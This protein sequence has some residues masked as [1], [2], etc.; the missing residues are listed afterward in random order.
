MFKKNADCKPLA[1]TNGRTLGRLS[2]ASLVGA[3]LFVASAPGCGNNLTPPPPEIGQEGIELVQGG[4]GQFL[5]PVTIGNQ[6]FNLLLDTGARDVLVFDDLIAADNTAVKRTDESVTLI[7]GSGPRIGKVAIAPIRVG[8]HSADDMRIMLV[9][10]PTSRGDPS[11]VP[12]M[13]D[14]IFGLRFN[15]GEVDD[16]G[17]D[18]DV[19]LLVLQPRVKEFQL[20]LPFDGSRASLVFGS[21]PVLEVSDPAFVFGVKTV[22]EIGEDRVNEN[23]ADLEVPFRVETRL[24]TANSSDL[25]I[26]LDTG[27][28][29]K[30]VLDREVAAQ[31]GFD[32]ETG[33]WNLDDDE[34]VNFFFVGNSGALPIEPAF[35][36]DEI[37]VTNLSG[38]TFDAVL[39]LDR[40]QQYIIGFTFVD[41]SLGGPDGTFRFL[42]RRDR[43]EAFRECPALSSNFVP[44]PGLNSTADDTSPNISADGSTIAFASDRSGGRGGIDFYLYRIGEGLIDTSALNSSANDVDPSVNEDGTLVVFVSDRNGGSDLF[45]YDLEAEAFIELPGLNTDDAPERSPYLSADGRYIAF[46]SERGDEPGETPSDIFLYDRDTQSLVD[47]PGLNSEADEF[48]PAISRNAGLITFDSPNR[49]D[50]Q[51]NEDV[52]IYDRNSAGLIQLPDIVNTGSFDGFVGVSADGRFLA[53]TSDGDTRASGSI[54]RDIKLF[55]RQGQ[56]PAGVVGSFADILGLNSE[57]EE[58]EVGLNEDGSLVVFHSRRCG[59]EGGLDI[60]LYR[61]D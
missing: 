16:S 40:W 19:P 31:I 34:L 2:S 36:V 21:Q 45:L 9:E 54:A 55:D 7:F 41:F 3:I 6:T 24:G 57:L 1:L 18:L 46:R 20:D 35:R 27:A 49:P 52:Y 58:G 47:L 5:V 14:G 22:T 61:R 23:F 32:R 48:C 26:L 10:S 25:D 38:T 51:G 43:E 28:V 29:S 39:G 50:G 8:T 56:G 44:L 15:P 11:L 33:R 30:L 53:F 60:Y 37:R 4:L 13:A 17:I 59:G 42:N 12:K